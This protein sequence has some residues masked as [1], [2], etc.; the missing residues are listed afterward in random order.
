MYLCATNLWSWKFRDEEPV[1]MFITEKGVIM[2][3]RCNRKGFKNCMAHHRRIVADKQNRSFV[4]LFGGSSDGL[5][6]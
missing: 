1:A 3:N 6:D 2:R 4:Y 5:C